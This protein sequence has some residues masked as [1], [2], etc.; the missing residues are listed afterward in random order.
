MLTGVISYQHGRGVTEDLIEGFKLCQKAANHG[1]AAAQYYL[2]N[3][4]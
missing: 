4:V 1:L 2:G 3:N